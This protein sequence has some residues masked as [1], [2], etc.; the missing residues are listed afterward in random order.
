MVAIKNGVIE[1]CLLKE[2]AGKKK[3]ISV[4]EEI[5]VQAEMLDICLGR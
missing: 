1:K 3:T 5:L 4:D 2:I